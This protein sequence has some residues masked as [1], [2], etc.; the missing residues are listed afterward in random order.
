V[1]RPL[2]AFA[3]IE[4]ALAHAGATMGVVARVRSILPN[5]AD[6]P[7]SRPSRRAAFGEVRT[8]ATMFEA[9]PAEPRMKIEIEA[10]AIIG[11]A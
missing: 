8:A 2:S 3:T 1:N 4:S 10:D 7:A 11:S 6:F 9:Q 5:A